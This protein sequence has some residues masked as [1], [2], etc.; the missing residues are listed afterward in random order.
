MLTVKMWTGKES[1]ALR[2]A[3]RATVAEFAG[4]LGVN[5]KAVEGWERGAGIR[6]Q[7]QAALDTLL[8]QAKPVVAELFT[9]IMTESEDDPNVKYRETVLATANSLYDLARADNENLAPLGPADLHIIGLV[10][11]VLYAAMLM[12]DAQGAPAA[13]DMVIAADIAARRLET[14]CPN[15]FA[16]ELL[17]LRAEIAAFSGCL[18]WDVGEHELAD[19]LY[20]RGHRMANESGRDDLAAY[21]LCHQA[22]LAVWGNFPRI[23]IEHAVAARAWVESSNDAALRSYV[24][25]RAAQAYAADG[26]EI[27]ARAALQDAQVKGLR[28]TDPEKSLVYYH[29]DA[30]YHGI[31]SECLMM[32]RDWSAAVDASEAALAGIDEKRVRDRALQALDLASALIGLG[33]PERAAR[34]VADAVKHVTKCPSPRL[35]AAV[36]EARRALSPWSATTAV[37]DLDEEIE[38]NAIVKA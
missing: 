29:S 11:R 16:H 24:A 22:Q 20:A 38:R 2:E 10:R 21:T 9:R 14:N 25:L 32:L 7:N 12:D 36:R 31:A 17:A 4:R 30:M 3:M 15:A 26:Q 8:W 5:P 34:T 27:P 6:P 28:E 19:T 35:V 1:R 13:L 37:R 18:A 33:E 23:A